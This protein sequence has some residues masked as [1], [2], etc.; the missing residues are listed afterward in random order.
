MY[1]RLHNIEKIKTLISNII[2]KYDERGGEREV[3]LDGVFFCKL[4]AK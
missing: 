3:F 2:N 4:F 1:Y